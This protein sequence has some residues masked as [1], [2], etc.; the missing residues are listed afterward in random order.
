MACFVHCTKEV[1]LGAEA[2]IGAAGKV[3]MKARLKSALSN[4]PLLKYGLLTLGGGL[5]IYGLVEQLYSSAAIMKY[6]L[7]SLLMVVV[8]VI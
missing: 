5:W 3:L 7:M 4:K 1:R 2:A 6:L 8:A